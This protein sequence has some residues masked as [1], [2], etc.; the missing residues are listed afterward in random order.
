MRI[1][2]LR[3]E[4]GFFDGVEV[5]FEA[6]L[7]VLIGGRG[8]GKTSIIEL[9]RY[10]LGAES[11]T[12]HGSRESI[13][14]ALAVLET[15]KVVIDLIKENGEKIIVSRSYKDDEP[16]YSTEYKRP[17]VFS[18]TEIESV[19]LDSEGRLKIIDTFLPMI[20]MADQGINEY[21]KNVRSS[22]ASLANLRMD[23]EELMEMVPNIK[24]LEKEESDLVA[25]QKKLLG[26]NELV[27]KSQERLEG[28]QEK[29]RNT[30]FEIE[31]L[32]DFSERINNWQE[33]LQNSISVEIYPSENFNQEETNKKLYKEIYDELKT[34]Y[35][36]I[37]NIRNK[38]KG[39]IEK[40]EKEVK[41]LKVENEPLEEQAR[42]L[43]GE[44]QKHNEGAGKV[45]KEISR[46][47]DEIAK[48]KK[49]LNQIDEK[50]KQLES[51]Y[52]ICNENIEFIYKTQ[53]IIF[54]KRREI[55]GDLNTS[56]KPLIS[57]SVDHLAHISEYEEELKKAL[58]GSGLRYNEI[59][60]VIAKNI[61]PQELL[62]MIYDKSF[63]E[64]S[65]VLEIPIERAT[66][67][68]SHLMVTDLGDLLSSKIDDSIN[69]YLLD[70]SKA[71][72]INE[73]SIG[74]RCTVTLSLILENKNNVLLIDQPEDHL[75][76][77]F[78]AETLIKA[79]A[80]RGIDTQTIISSHNA[81][82]PVLGNAK[83][84]I[85]LDSNGRQGFVNVEGPLLDHEIVNLIE[86]I[87]E[88]GKEAFRKRANFYELL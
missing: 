15:G 58:Q 4:E 59:S 47:R 38:A 29:I 73:L 21:R 61:S 49:I 70:G 50:N 23:L 84:V 81:N 6:G 87:M 42:G 54:N 8:V 71:K 24:E 78:I 33:G 64:F 14:H 51:A 5:S 66:R 68:I 37:K 86:K 12:S 28:L 65:E 67:L 7:N 75:D 53:E 3:I 72:S 30:T 82:I 11:F 2:K 79:I 18:Q 57:V 52:K 76:N 80:Q 1:S 36:A 60:G 43:R 69:F 10:C 25:S 74:Q 20:D 13:N 48:A 88:G 63:E 62:S 44:I 22:A 35:K 34:D 19:G 83:K 77:E 39:Y 31:S 45:S 56:L 55:A 85:S 9:I 41:R 40:I 46:V 16:N 17:I 32:Q 27:N 26:K